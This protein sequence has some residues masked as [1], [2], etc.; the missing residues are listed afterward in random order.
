M[1]S[2]TPQ[3]QGRT[4]YVSALGDNS[5]GSTWAKAFNTIQSAFGAVPDDLGGHRVVIRPDTYME[6]N[7]HPAHRGALGSY[8]SLEVDYDGSMGSGA[9]GYAVVDVS[10]PNRGMQSVDWWGFPRCTPDFPGVTWDRWQLRHIYATGG[11]G[12]L[13]WDLPYIF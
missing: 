7:L 5:D 8:N 11:D 4:I 9:S 13:F 12:G 2:H 10:D 1:T 6:G 3:R